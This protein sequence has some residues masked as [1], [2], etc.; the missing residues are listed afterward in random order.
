MENDDFFDRQ[1]KL[2][3]LEGFEQSARI[4][5]DEDEPDDNKILECALC[6]KADYIVSGDRHLLEL[7]EYKGIK[8][9]PTK[10]MLEI[11]K[12]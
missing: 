6:G 8:I 4:P 1:R 3:D 12:N 5:D 11:F 2:Q 10:R 9:L 7:E